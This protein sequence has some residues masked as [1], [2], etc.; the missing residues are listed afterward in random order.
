M[1]EREG[2]R[3]GDDRLVLRDEVKGI[4]RRNRRR[5][6]IAS[7]RRHLDSGKKNKN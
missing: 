3:G 2:I 4:T 7:F 6:D 5:V 1:H